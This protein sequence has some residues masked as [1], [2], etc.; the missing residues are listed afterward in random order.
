MTPTALLYPKAKVIAVIKLPFFGRSISLS[1]YPSV[2]LFFS[3]S[4]SYTHTHTHT[5]E[6]CREGKCGRL[7]VT[8]AI[9]ESLALLSHCHTMCGPRLRTGYPYKAIPICLPSAIPE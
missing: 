6:W 7:T 5:Q 2:S 8:T 3:V 9:S 1:L 4:V